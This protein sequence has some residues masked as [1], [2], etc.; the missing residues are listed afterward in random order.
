MTI[1][2]E[3]L[4]NG[5]GALFGQPLIKE[6]RHQ[7]EIRFATQKRRISLYLRSLWGR[8]FHLEA[9][10]KGGQAQLRHGVLYLPESICAGDAD[11]AITLYRA[12]AIHMASHLVYTQNWPGSDPGFTP[13]QRH[14]IELVEDARVEQNTIHHYPG[15]KKLWSDF[16]TPSPQ[17]HEPTP[18]ELILQRIPLALHDRHHPVADDEISAWIGRFHETILFNRDNAAVSI[19]LGL[20]L[21]DIIAERHELNDL[22]SQGL[23]RLPYRDDGAYLWGGK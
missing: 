10:P 21:H 7:Y 15:I 23:A 16:M 20:E 12:M 2:V 11:R 13:L 3:T 4:G 6:F 17:R 22:R 9:L 14:L 1:S 18:A 19:G 5:S 8:N